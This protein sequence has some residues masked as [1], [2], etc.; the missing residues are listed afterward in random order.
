MKY[1][2]VSIALI[3]NNELNGSCEQSKSYINIQTL[4]SLKNS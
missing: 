1:K 4:V 2:V 3:D